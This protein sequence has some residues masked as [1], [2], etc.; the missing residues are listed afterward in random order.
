[1]QPISKAAVNNYIRH[2][3]KALKTAQEWGYLPVSSK[4]QAEGRIITADPLKN[5]KQYHV[6]HHVPHYADESH[7]KTL[8]DAASKFKYMQTA[9]ALQYFL[10]MGRAPVPPPI[11][12]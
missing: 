5:F 9:M 6:S 1:M 12:P 10:G 3:R 8:L 11:S 7:I 4:Q 2:L